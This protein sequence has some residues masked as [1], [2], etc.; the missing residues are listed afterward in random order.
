MGQRLIRMESEVPE[1]IQL[2]ESE[3]YARAT[4][5][6]RARAKI[7][8]NLSYT[9]LVRRGLRNLNPPECRSD[10]GEE[11]WR[12]EWFGNKI[13]SS[14]VQRGNFVFFRIP[15]R[16]HNDC[17][18]RVIPNGAACSKSTH[19]GHVDIKHNQLRAK[20]TYLFERVF[21]RL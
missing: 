7:D 9:Y 21:A 17:H 8:H 12:A 18:V 6:Y 2:F 16:K 11:F 14:G 19:S 5:R 15:N 1:K 4:I 20:V 3:M 13:V 10:A